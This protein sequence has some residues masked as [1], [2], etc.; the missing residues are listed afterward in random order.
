[1]KHITIDFSDKDW[2]ILE[3]A[4]NKQKKTVQQ[5]IRDTLFQR[6][7][8]IFTVEEAERRAIARLS[9]GDEFQLPDLYDDAEWS[10]LSLSSAGV[11]GRRWFNYIEGNPSETPIEFVRMFRRRATYRIKKTEH[12]DQESNN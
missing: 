8:T 6:K 11:F 9:P 7:P 12:T 1:M 5:H 10:T 4:A 2:E 3:S